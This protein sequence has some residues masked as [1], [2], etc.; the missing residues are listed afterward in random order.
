ALI[1]ALDQCVTG[2]RLWVPVFCCALLCGKSVGRKHWAT[3]F[4]D[5]SYVHILLMLSTHDLCKYFILYDV[6]NVLTGY[7]LR[8]LC[9]LGPSST[10]RKRSVGRFSTSVRVLGLSR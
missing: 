2:R 4:S 1:D 8:F 3:L 5:V 9:I 7:Y 6:W 10:R